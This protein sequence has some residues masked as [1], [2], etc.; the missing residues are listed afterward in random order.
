MVYMQSYKRGNVDCYIAKVDMCEQICVTFVNPV[1]QC[2][3]K[4]LNLSLRYAIL[5]SSLSFFLMF[6]REPEISIDVDMDISGVPFRS[7]WMPLSVP[8]EV[9]RLF[10]SCPTLIPPYCSLPH[11]NGVHWWSMSFRLPIPRNA[12]PN[13]PTCFF[14]LCWPRGQSRADPS[15]LQK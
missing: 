3:P 9:S 2:L 4:N 5:A 15:I 11:L 6:R 13:I 12:C 8:C 1:D 14:L 7:F 10:I